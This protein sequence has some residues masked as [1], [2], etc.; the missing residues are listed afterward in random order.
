MMGGC[1]PIR[2]VKI[3]VID[4]DPT[5]SQT[6]HGC[7]LLLRWDPDTLAA[8]LRDPS[9][10]LFVLSNSRALAPEGAAARVRQICRALAPALAA[11]VAEG[12]IDRWLVVSR[13]DSTLRSHFPLEVEVIAAELGP[14]DATLLVPA[15]LEGG[16]TTVHGVHRL[17][18]RP[19][20]ESE[21]SRDRLLGFRSSYLPAWV[22]ERS[23]GRIPAAA[24]ARID[25]AELDAAV[26]GGEGRRALVERLAAFEAN[27][28]VAVDAE[29][30]AHLA[31]LAAAVRQLA[32]APGGRPRR[33]LLQS[34][35]GLLP[36]LAQLPPPPLAGAQLAGL[37]RRDPAGTLLPGLVVVG[38]HVPLADAQLAALLEEP[39]CAGVEVQVEKVL[40]VLEGPLPDR[41]LRSL[42]QAWREGLE[43][44]LASGRT[45][46]LFTS[47]GETPCSGAGERRRLG[48]VL[49]GITARL[50]AA[51]A[52][53]LGY[54]LS[55]GGIT[56]QTLL[57]EGLAVDRV[58]LQGQLLPGLSLV[59][60]AQDR[61]GQAP[62]PVLT[63]PG[64]LGDGDTLRRAW[65]CMETPAS[66]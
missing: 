57:A 12:T 27:R 13:G 18:G 56:S 34:A 7:P 30:P 58:Q 15:F 66:A 41:M 51:Q 28:I 46:V 5:G 9:P 59:L 42:E 23:G 3:V 25:V 16:R 21:F 62:L 53:R 33:F 38:S 39:G 32:G 29:R 64:N 35:A 49:A 47:R 2:S 6:V 36:H 40:R 63:M 52:P 26:A 19:V 24:V 31:Q 17:H 54:V 10:L 20:H 50:A 22:E 65:R 60:A 14:F 55:K 43:R 45:P 4:D 48:T 44:V 1:R 8:A 37:R 11:A 61:D